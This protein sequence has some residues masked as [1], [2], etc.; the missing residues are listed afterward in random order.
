[1]VWWWSV[2]E[3]EYSVS[4]WV[5]LSFP[6]GPSLA[7][8]LQS[9]FHPRP[10]EQLSPPVSLLPSLSA[11][12]PNYFLEDLLLL[13][14][15]PQPSPNR[16][17]CETQ[18]LEG[19][20]NIP[21]LVGWEMEELPAHLLAQQVQKQSSHHFTHGDAYPPGG[22]GFSGAV[23]PGKEVFGRGNARVRTLMEIL[24]QAVTT[25]SFSLQELLVVSIGGLVAAE[26]SGQGWGRHSVCVCSVT[27][28]CSPLC[29]PMDCSLPGCSFHGIF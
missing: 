4:F 25:S 29:D 2:Q 5:S 3:R 26:F 1:M 9:T 18:K 10:A 20:G 27:H 12:S 15:S 8:G 19:V 23:V 22:A 21:S 11:G 14:M 13:T 17:I 28:S 24:V 16:R 6:G 7:C